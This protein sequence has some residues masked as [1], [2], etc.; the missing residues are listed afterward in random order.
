MSAVSVLAR[1]GRDCV[2]TC[3][4]MYLNTPTRFWV[5]LKFKV[6]GLSILHYGCEDHLIHKDL[7]PPSL[8][9]LMAMM[10]VILSRNL[11]QKPQR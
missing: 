3:V 9:K 7:T 4:C 1:I 10:M 6:N 5:N 11:P 8:M 2:C